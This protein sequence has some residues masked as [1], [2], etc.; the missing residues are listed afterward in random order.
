M[1][2]AKPFAHRACAY[3]FLEALFQVLGQ[4]PTLGARTG[5][6]ER[7][8]P[9]TGL[10]Q[11]N[12]V[13]RRLCAALCQW[14]GQC[15]SFGARPARLLSAQP[16]AKRLLA[17]RGGAG[18]WPP[19]LKAPH[20]LGLWP[21]RSSCAVRAPCAH[22]RKGNASH[23]AKRF[24]RRAG[25]RAGARKACDHHFP[26]PRARTKGRAMLRTRLSA[27]KDAPATGK[28][29]KGLR[30]SLHLSPPKAKQSLVKGTREAPPCA[31]EPQTN[32]GRARTG[33]RPIRP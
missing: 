7:A 22:Q 31:K 19:P 20:W 6:R 29:E 21:V 17:I 1:R 10:S 18:A 4:C 16:M 28:G 13:A 8:V 26:F 15:S 5:E 11:A 32:S 25:H 14:Q 24:Q 23:M 9:G 30:E 12:A 3:A 27:S 2:I 33:P